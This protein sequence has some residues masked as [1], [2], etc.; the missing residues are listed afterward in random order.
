[1]Q[2]SSFCQAL[3]EL[4]VKAPHSEKQLCGWEDLEITSTPAFSL[5]Q[6]NLCQGRRLLLFFDT[7]LKH[8]SPTFFA[9]RISIM[10]DSSFR[11]QPLRYGR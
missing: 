5:E 10:S 1:M 2:H 6:E 4:H 11:N 9:P 3:H 7:H 8:R